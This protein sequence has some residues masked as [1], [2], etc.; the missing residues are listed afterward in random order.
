MKYNRS[1]HE[2]FPGKSI[3]FS[4]DAL[5]PI[6]SEIK[7]EAIE[8]IFKYSDFL[9]FNY[10]TE[11]YFPGLLFE[12]NL[13]TPEDNYSKTTQTLIENEILFINTYLE[14]IRKIFRQ[15]NFSEDYRDLTTYVN[16]GKLSSEDNLFLEVLKEEDLELEDLRPI[17][18][19]WL[20][21]KFNFEL[22]YVCSVIYLEITKI[23]NFLISKVPSS[24]TNGKKVQT[25]SNL[26]EKVHENENQPHTNDSLK[27]ND[28][29]FSR[30]TPIYR[31]LEYNGFL[32]CG[33]V[34]FKKLFS[35]TV[36]FTPVEWLKEKRAL[37]YFYGLIVH[38]GLI[39]KPRPMWDKLPELFTSAI[40][41][42]PKSAK[43]EWS[44]RNKGEGNSELFSL[45]ESIVNKP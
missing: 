31:D 11:V 19:H 17:I 12:K 16:Q 1:K 29:E 15:F 20:S 42:K 41:I 27:W 43:T 45:M 24:T 26:K 14:I 21:G 38:T 13:N 36:D 40:E 22:L 34:N 28:K 9:T 7:H 23:F 3:G 8:I 30:L 6:K 10:Y 32:D 5:F 37:A 25:F 39:R 35:E 33:L 2:N 18:S 4:P 44:R